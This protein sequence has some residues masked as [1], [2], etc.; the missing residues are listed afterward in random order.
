M[1]QSFSWKDTYPTTIVGVDPGTDTLGTAIISIDPRTFSILSSQSRTFMAGRQMTGNWRT[2]YEG[3]KLARLRFLKESL[4]H[5]FN[6]VQ[7]MCVVAE[8]NF[9]SL[10]RPMAYGALVEA[11]A[12]VREAL[13]DWHPGKV[14][15]MVEPNVA[16]ASVGATNF[17]DK[18]AVLNALLTLPINYVGDLAGID[19][20]SSDALAIA[21]SKYIE[22]RS[23]AF[24][25]RELRASYG[26]APLF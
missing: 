4:Y 23:A 15:H 24:A 10:R 17:R 21:Y 18:Q 6:T 5:L 19:E 26:L 13:Y 1:W 16:K 11:V 3:E 25:E 20:H 14:L 9:I 2:E 8:S 12:C 7:P 22:L